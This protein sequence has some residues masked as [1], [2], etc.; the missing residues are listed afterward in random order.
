MKVPILT[1]HGF[2]IIGLSG[3]GKPTAVSSD[4]LVLTH[5]AVRIFYGT[6]FRQNSIPW[7]KFTDGKGNTYIWENGE[8]SD[9]TPGVLFELTA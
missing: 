7:A 4:A 3:T 8:W 5:G 2:R 6:I 1:L 9:G